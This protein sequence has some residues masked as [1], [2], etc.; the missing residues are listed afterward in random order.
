MSVINYIGS[1]LTLS[2]TIMEH[3]KRLGGDSFLDGFAG[4]GIIGTLASQSGFRVTSNDIQHYS[5]VLCYAR[6]KS[7]VDSERVRQII[8]ELN[9][10][11]Q[12]ESLEGPI[13]RLYCIDRQYFSLQNG[14]RID[15]AVD[16]IQRYKDDLDLYYYLMACILSSADRVANT[17][18]VYG[19]YLKH[20][21]K[22]A[23][24]PFVVADIADSIVLA[25]SHE[26]TVRLGDIMDIDGHYDI[27]YLDPPY[28]TRQYGSNYHV[29]ET[30]SRADNPEVK[31][32][33]GLRNYFR[34][35]F[36]SKRKVRKAFNDLLQR[37]NC[38]YVLL[39]YS[40]GGILP[41]DDMLTVLENHG[42]VEVV[43][44]DYPQFNS[45][46]DQESKRVTEYLFIVEKN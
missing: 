16:Y 22:S 9:T 31:G 35:L 19:A 43:E 4:T 8:T 21:K 14:R 28:N 7:V 36:C 5:Y 46:R 17:A 12:A 30:I 10:T 26:N 29:L 39:S 15:T 33:T 11:L 23:Q 25:P 1:K 6:T 44:V 13:T 24:K 32:K 37:L 41:Y 42:S 18:S 34:S 2:D 38:K 45:H 40:T 27:V 3:V 20:I